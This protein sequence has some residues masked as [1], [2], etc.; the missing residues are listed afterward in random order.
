MSAVSCS[1]GDNTRAVLNFEP[2]LDHAFLVDNYR[3]LMRRLYEPGTFYRRV[4]IYLDAH[5]VRGP[6]EALSYRG[7]GALFRSCWC[8]GV[9]HRGRR[10]YWRFLP[11][12]LRRH[13]DQLGEAVTMAI[14]GYHF[15]MVAADL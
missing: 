11:G 8:M 13:P 9:R 10:D 6:R 3:R 5:A 15:R 7:M 12:T 14:M 2:R 4:R 1:L